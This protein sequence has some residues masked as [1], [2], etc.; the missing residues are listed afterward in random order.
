[1]R[2]RSELHLD[3]LAGRATITVIRKQLSSSGSAAPRHTKRRG[4]ASFQLAASATV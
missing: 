4:A 1:M 2:T 3:R